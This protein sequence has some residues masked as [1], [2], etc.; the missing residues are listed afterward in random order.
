MGKVRI[1]GGFLRSRILTFKSEVAGFRPTPDRVRETIFNWLGQDLSDK[2]IL[3]LFAGAGSLGFE[4]ISRNAAA[5]TMVENS[6]LAIKDL[7]LNKELL[8]CENLTIE[9]NDAI[10]FLRACKEKFDIIFIDAPYE[11]DLLE[12]ALYEIIRSKFAI[13]K[14]DGLIY[15]EY[16]TKPNLDG[17]EIIKQK[18]AGTVNYALIKPPLNYEELDDVINY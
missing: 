15:I 4:A 18:K 11:S 9:K 2:M 10:R 16:N 14:K 17:F 6:Q 7:Y 12:K 13:L 5:V 3:D 8:K 1:I